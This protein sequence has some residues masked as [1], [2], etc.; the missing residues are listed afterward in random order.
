MPV[1]S[2]A[3]I[4]ALA[5]LYGNDQYPV[6]EYCIGCS[7]CECYTFPCLNCAMYVFN[8]QLGEGN[9]GGHESMDID[10]D[11]VV[12][13]NDIIDTEMDDGGHIPSDSDSDS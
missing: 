4:R 12:N 13:D 1:I 2:D 8:G 11:D 3:T 6:D 5:E 9:I 10:D 7:N